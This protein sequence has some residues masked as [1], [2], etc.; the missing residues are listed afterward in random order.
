MVTQSTKKAQRLRTKYA[1]EGKCLNCGARPPAPSRK[2]CE[3]CLASSRRSTRQYRVRNPDQFRD[4][5]HQLKG[6]GVCTS[7]KVPDKPLRTGTQC[8]DCSLAERQRAVR[9]KWEV[10]QKYGGSCACCG[11]SKV[12]FLTIDHINDDGAE[13]RRAGLHTGGFYKKLRRLPVD[14]TLRV[15]CYNCNLGRRATGVCPHQD[16]NFY[17]TALAR[18]RYQRHEDK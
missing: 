10:M 11:E 5:Y 4:D 18:D 13:K 7:C 3:K 9:V 14:P 2:R 12:A 1:S 8:A 16:D 15:L 6:A 17:L